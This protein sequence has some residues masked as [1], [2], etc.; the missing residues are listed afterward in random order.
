ME[1]IDLLFSNI[2]HTVYITDEYGYILDY[3]NKHPFIKIRKGKNL[4]NYIKDALEINESKFKYQDK[5]FKKITTPIYDNTDIVNYVIMLMD[6]T[7]LEDITNKKLS[8]QKDLDEAF[9]T[10]KKSNDDYYKL[11]TQIREIT[12]Y[13]DQIR[14]SRI[15]HDNYGHTITEI[16]AISNM[17]LLCK[18][19]NKFNELTDLG[20]NIIDKA[21]NKEQKNYNS[22]KELFD[23][24]YKIDEFP[25]YL[26]INGVEPIWLKDKYEVISKIFKETYHNT[27]D[28][29]FGNE[30]YINFFLN[31]EVV[32]EIYDNGIFHGT[33]EKGFG[34]KTMEDYVAKSNGNIEFIAQDG[35]NFKIIVKWSKTNG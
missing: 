1:N 17:L 11:I 16:N 12:S 9:I 18:D 13:G 34:L 30:M 24:L 21:I 2:P 10:L 4:S 35:K 27:L 15:I 20:I 31:D 6:I 25:V 8:T 5:V 7:S 29:S 23:S 33:F 19:D 3:N 22:I 28:H 14:L 26:N 32:L